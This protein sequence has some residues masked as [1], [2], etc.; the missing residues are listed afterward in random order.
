MRST[1]KGV[2]GASCPGIHLEKQSL[3]LTL[4]QDVGLPQGWELLPFP[5]DPA[6]SPRGGGVSS[7]QKKPAGVGKGNCNPVTCQLA[8]SKTQAK[9]HPGAQRLSRVS[10][11]KPE[12]PKINIAVFFVPQL[13]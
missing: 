3:A 2:P 1:G 11:Q 6:S 5:A 8:K 4:W 13:E 9:L 10:H 12:H 7:A